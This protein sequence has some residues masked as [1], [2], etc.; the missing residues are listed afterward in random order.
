MKYDFQSNIR[1]LIKYLIIAA[2]ALIIIFVFSYIKQ[3]YNENYSK[4]LQQ[5]L[6]TIEPTQTYSNDVD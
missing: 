4:T 5:K 3:N 1:L 6:N 2:I